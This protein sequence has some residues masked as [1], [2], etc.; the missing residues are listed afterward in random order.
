MERDNR[1]YKFDSRSAEALG[2]QC[3]REMEQA[4]GAFFDEVTR[5]LKMATRFCFQVGEK[6]SDGSAA[7]RMFFGDA[8]AGRH[9]EELDQAYQ[10]ELSRGNL[11]AAGH[12]L[13]R[14]LVLSQGTRGYDSPISEKLRGA[15]GA[16]QTG[17]TTGAWRWAGGSLGAGRSALYFQLAQSLPQR[18]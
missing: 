12:Y 3:D 11:A 16:A 14:E 5:E 8:G 9:L 6:F 18:S 4:S 10:K 15:I 7:A 13:K 17:S 1:T 2:T